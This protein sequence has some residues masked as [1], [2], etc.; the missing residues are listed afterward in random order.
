ML[1]KI[2]Y[3]KTYPEIIPAQIFLKERFTDHNLV[4]SLFLTIIIITLSLYLLLTLSFIHNYLLLNIQKA[5]VLLQAGYPITRIYCLLFLIG[6]SPWLLL[7]A[8]NLIITQRSVNTGLFTLI[9]FIEFTIL[10]VCLYRIKY[11]LLKGSLL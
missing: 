3:K 5:Q 1:K 2:S 7:T 10:Y 6:C 4:I 9:G 11:K 8:Y